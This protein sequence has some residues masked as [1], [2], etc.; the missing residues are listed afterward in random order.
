MSKP[1]LAQILTYA[2]TLPFLAACLL[3]AY[4]PD[5][6]GLNY[7]QLILT[8]GAIIASFIAGT[9]WGLYLYKDAPVNLFVHSNIIALLA[10]V[11]LLAAIPG[12]SGLLIIAF[13][14]LLFMDKQMALAGLIEPWYMRMRIVATA[15]VNIALCLHLLG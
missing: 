10:W 11:A 1:F 3:A 9:H 6:L 5:F 14:Y 7:D 8:Y 13:V 15:I 2:G 4:A 12:S